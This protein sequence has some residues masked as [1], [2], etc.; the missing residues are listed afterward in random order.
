MNQSEVFFCWVSQNIFSFLWQPL[1]L[2]KSRYFVR[3]CHIKDFSWPLCSW[4]LSVFALMTSLW[5]TCMGQCEIQA[6]NHQ[7]CGLF[8]ITLPPSF[9][10]ILLLLAILSCVFL[11]FLFL[12]CLIRL[13]NFPVDY[14]NTHLNLS[15]LKS[16]F[17][18]SFNEFQFY[19][20]SDWC[21]LIDWKCQKS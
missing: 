12:L 9:M 21:C 17:V 2:P 7:F 3:K 4:H 15:D 1:V 14:L 13:N 19:R 6:E 18:F 11:C 10:V 8:A 5:Q 20:F 16:V